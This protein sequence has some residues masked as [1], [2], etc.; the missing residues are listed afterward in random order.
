MGSGHYSVGIMLI[1]KFGGTSVGSAERIRATAEIVKKASA[2]QPC[3]LVLSAMSGVTNSLLDIAG[4]HDGAD[5]LFGRHAAAVQELG[6]PRQVLF[7]LQEIFDQARTRDEIVACG[8]LFSTT[9]MLAFL[10]KQGV[11]AVWLPALEYMRVDADGN[12]LPE[13]I[14]ARVL[15]LIA[16]KGEHRVYVT[17]GFIGRRSDNGAI[18]TLSRGGSDYTATLL[19]EALGAEEV[20]I[21][22][23]VDG[24]YSA[25]PRVVP[26]ARCIPSMSYS[27]ADTAARRGAK[28]L[29]PECVRPAMRAAYRLRV[30]DSFH[31]DA[32]GTLIGPFDDAE[33]VVALACSRGEEDAVISI[34]G[35]SAALNAADFRRLSE[36]TGVR[37]IRRENGCVTLVA[38]PEHADGIMR[39]VHRL[40]FE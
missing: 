21:W 28:I 10:Y 5:A 29:H 15:P 27:Q 18:A 26:L 6:L 13:E 32:H 33:G 30:L 25:D 24:V 22:T 16:R 2:V 39:E 19:G 36:L 3:V 17:Q 23:D 31:P 35:H 12:P 37:R 20:Q 14:K 40:F 11:D 4:G 34:I 7:R 9:I 38:D 8:E 1:L